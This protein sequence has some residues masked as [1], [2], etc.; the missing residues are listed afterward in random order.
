MHSDSSQNWFSYELTEGGKVE[1]DDVFETDVHFKYSIIFN[2]KIKNKNFVYFLNNDD[3][4]WCIREIDDT[5]AKFGKY[6]KD[7]TLEITFQTISNFQINDKN[8]NNWRNESE[9]MDDIEI[10]ETAEQIPWDINPINEMN[11]PNLVFKLSSP[12]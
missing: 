12:R 11:Y 5:T 3:E 4:Y 6:I 10:F 7:N 9:P 1:R 8:W 2:Y